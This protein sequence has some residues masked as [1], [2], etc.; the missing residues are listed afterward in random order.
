M[1]IL[2]AKQGKKRG[3]LLMLWRKR[4][5]Y[6]QD[7]FDLER[8]AQAILD[9]KIVKEVTSSQTGILGH[10]AYIVCDCCEQTIRSPSQTGILG[11]LALPWRPAHPY[12]KGS[13]SQTGILGHLAPRSCFKCEYKLPVSI[14]N[15]HPRPF[16]H[17][18]H[19]AK[20]GFKL[21]SPSQTGTLGHLAHWRG[22]AV[23]GSH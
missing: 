2:N 4:S 12:C 11:H 7:T 15:G 17:K 9:E 8:A 14:P 10:L 22:W 13:P 18:V 5:F 6:T 20:S 3:A 19:M 1:P 23:H 16:S 21:R